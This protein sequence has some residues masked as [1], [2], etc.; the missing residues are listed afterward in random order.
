ME[1]QA[2]VLKGNV[3]F[4]KSKE[5]IQAIPQAYLV[6][7]NGK[8]AGVFTALPQRFANLPLK[9]YGRALI[10]P[11]LVD[12]HLHA[13]QFSFRALGM[14]LELLEWLNTNTFPEEAKYADLAYAQKAYQIF[15]DELVDGATTRA[16]I[17][18][19]LHVPA[20]L[21][22][23][24]MLEKS[25]LATL[26]GK[27]NMNRNSPDNLCEPGTE[28]S[29]AATREWLLACQ[30]RYR[31]TH[32]ILTPRFIPSCTDDLMR[33]LAAIQKETGLSVQS[34]LSENRSEIGWVQE[35]CPNSENYGD[36]YRQLGL[37][38]GEGCPTIMAHCVYSGAEE[39]RLLKE[40]GVFVAHSPN[41]NTCLSSGIAP[42]R[43]FLQEEIH[44]GLATDVAG[45]FSPS[46]FRAMADAVQVSKLYWRLLDDTKPSLS[47]AEAFYLGTKG[48]GEFFGKVGSLE[49]G[50][51]FDAVV[52]E[53][54]NL[55]CPYELSLHQRL[56]RLV[57]LG[58]NRNISAKYVEGRQV[59]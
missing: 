22:L 31:N 8:V 40:N 9:D 37:F 57:Y 23:M 25:G 35:L 10:I 14:D 53:D 24:D 7:E 58:D 15:V 43:Q 47:M 41:S 52:L 20:T 28:A 42:V 27:V 48:G 32:P 1:Q 5:E 11:G 59:K 34:H 54:E 49:E 26:V 51:A 50:Y 3:L 30:G 12:L 33:G 39:R 38:G 56:E 13:P 16:S 29:L 45:G 4:S 6:C 55:P 36:A 2:F 17:F 21:L 19:T 18:A 44:V 46:I